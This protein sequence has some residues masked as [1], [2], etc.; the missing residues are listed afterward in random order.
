MVLRKMYKIKAFSFC[1]K[2][3]LFF[4]IL[5]SLVKIFSSVNKSD[6]KLPYKKKIRQLCILFRQRYER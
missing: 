4:S 1:Y 6:N 5:M 2:V 3:L